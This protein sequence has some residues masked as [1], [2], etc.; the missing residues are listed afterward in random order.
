MSIAW[1]TET[2]HQISNVTTYHFWVV[3]SLPRYT[4]QNVP[5]RTWHAWYRQLLVETIHP[6]Q[7]RGWIGSCSQVGLEMQIH[8]KW[9]P[10]ILGITCLLRSS[11]LETGR[12]VWEKTALS[13]KYYVDKRY[14]CVVFAKK[15]GKL[16]RWWISRDREVFFASIDQWN[17]FHLLLICDMPACGH[18][19]TNRC[20]VV[21]VLSGG[22][23][24]LPP[25]RK[26]KA[27]RR[28]ITNAREKLSTVRR[29]SVRLTQTLFREP[30]ELIHITVMNLV[31]VI[32]LNAYV[33]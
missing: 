19:V 21:H 31:H 27:K 12:N 4:L 3:R 13:S 6:W 30:C 2:S 23:S 11:F 16:I 20:G 17:T 5:R 32:E 33:L 26:H 8:S 9:L 10:P 22:F 29:A 15:N 28:L 25:Q 7:P 24:F 14:V 18:P 1:N